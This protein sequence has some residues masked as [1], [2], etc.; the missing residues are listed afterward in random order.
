MTQKRAFF[1]RYDENNEWGMKAHHDQ[2][3]AETTWPTYEEHDL[4]GPAGIVKGWWVG[5]PRLGSDFVTSPVF[6][7]GDYNDNPVD[8]FKKGVVTAG[9]EPVGL[10]N[11]ADTNENFEFSPRPDKTGVY[12]AGIIHQ[13]AAFHKMAVAGSG[14][15]L[16]GTLYSVAAVTFRFERAAG[17]SFLV[18]GSGTHYNIM[19][20]DTLEIELLSDFQMELDNIAL[21]DQVLAVLYTGLDVSN[22]GT[23]EFWA[24]EKHFLPSK[25][26]DTDGIGKWVRSMPA[27]DIRIWIVAGQF[28]DLPPPPEGDT[29]T[30]HM[31]LREVGDDTPRR[32]LYFSGPLDDPN[33]QITLD[34]NMYL[35]TEEGEGEKEFVQWESSAWGWTDGKEE[36]N[37]ITIMY[38]DGANLILRWQ[39]KII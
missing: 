11:T 39:Y 20:G 3:I 30:F 16:P 13:Y 9:D 7:N 34:A 6:P 33:N 38:K 10:A 27:E 21:A 5:V 19:E 14:N 17:W 24:T 2:M 26:V 32:G 18:S 8:L 22:I 15:T 37:P 4:G 1:Y 36:T 23:D 28:D 12:F 29:A 25:G 31:E 35:L